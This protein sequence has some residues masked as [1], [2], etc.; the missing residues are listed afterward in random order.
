MK[1][2]LLKRLQS[3][4]L[5]GA[6]T[7]LS[8]CTVMPE[9]SEPGYESAAPIAMVRPE[10]NT[11]SL[12]QTGYDM[13]LFEDQRASR[14]GDIIQ[15]LL[16]E[17]TDAAKTSKTEIDKDSKTTLPAPT[18]FG[19]L[20]D[21]LGIGLDSSSEFEG[22]GKSNQSNHLSGSIAVTV[23]QVLPNGNLV[24]QGEKWIQ[25]NQGG[26]FIRIKGIVR[27]SDVSSNNTVRS[28]HIADAKISYGGKGAVSESNVTGW[29]VRFFMS[30]LWPF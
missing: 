19:E 25:I 30:P 16:V 9:Q 24:V 22:E 6:V 26:E 21:D 23:S 14:V 10:Q 2:A 8:A 11:G 27:P 1:T 17:Q 12:Y 28:T 3:I 15:V 13:V 5:L 7:I 4:C 20:L 29:V 18:L